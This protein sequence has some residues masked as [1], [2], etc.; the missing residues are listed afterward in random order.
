[1]LT[2]REVLSQLLHLPHPLPSRHRSCL[3]VVVDDDVA[4]RANYWKQIDR[5]RMLQRATDPQM[6]PTPV[7]VAAFTDALGLADPGDPETISGRKIWTGLRGLDVDGLSPFQLERVAWNA[8]YDR[9]VTHWKLDDTQAVALD[10]A[11]SW[12]G[13]IHAECQWLE[14]PSDPEPVD[15]LEQ[16]VRSAL[17]LP[18]PRSSFVSSNHHYPAAWREE[19]REIAYW[20]RCSAIPNGIDLDVF[21]DTP[22]VDIN[23]AVELEHVLDDVAK[24]CRGIWAPRVMLHDDGTLSL[25]WADLTERGL[26]VASIH[27]SGYCARTYCRTYAVRE[28]RLMHDESVVARYPLAYLIGWDDSPSMLHKIALDSV[29]S[30]TTLLTQIHDY[31]WRPEETQAFY[32]VLKAMSQP[33]SDRRLRA[34]LP[35]I[36]NRVISTFAKAK[37]A[38]FRKLTGNAHEAPGSDEIERP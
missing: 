3:N 2:F 30:E 37:M 21:P 34:E 17:Y 22:A 5:A 36:G 29:P 15:Q 13:N 26:R 14:R 33:R 20:I 25:A 12:T 27:Q 32:D 19:F 24:R 9:I 1:M 4:I 28:L 38:S 7:P 6:Q 10:V 23:S 11:F 16:A 8:L 35:I 18:R 31:T